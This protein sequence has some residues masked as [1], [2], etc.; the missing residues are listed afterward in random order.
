MSLQGEISTTIHLLNNFKDSHSI[1][2][3]FKRMEVHTITETVWDLQRIS[4]VT[5]SK[6][7]LFVGNIM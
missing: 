6:I 1:G 4:H 2:Q 3:S 7:N 5:V